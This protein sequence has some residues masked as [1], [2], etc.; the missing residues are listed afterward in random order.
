MTWWTQ[1]TARERVMIAAMGSVMVVFIAYQF[2]YVPLVDYR[3]TA[4]R[5]AHSAE[6][7]YREVARGAAQVAALR[8]TVETRPARPAGATMRKTV[9]VSAYKAQITITRLEPQSDG[10]GVWINDVAIRDLHTWIGVLSSD[11][12]ITVRR[13]TIS[14]PTDR[15]G[16]DAQAPAVVRAQL[17]FAEGDNR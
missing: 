9:T 10:L 5:R 11:H 2:V 4:E 3:Q 13:A 17:L 1:R 8:E 12:G 6:A 15:S 7:L 16:A 14:R